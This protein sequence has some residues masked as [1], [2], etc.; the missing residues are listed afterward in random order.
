MQKTARAG[1]NSPRSRF[2]K[3]PK[4]GRLTLL[5]ACCLLLAAC[6]LLLATCYLL[7]AEH[8]S[9]NLHRCQPLR[10]NFTCDIIPASPARRKHICPDERLN[11]CAASAC[12]GS[13]STYPP[14]SGFTASDCSRP[15]KTSVALWLR[16]RF[17]H[18]ELSDSCPPQRFS[19]KNQRY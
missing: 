4:K 6:Y 18:A 19:E 3:M 1:L 10:H 7:L 13:S 9:R 17:H 14:P 8:H 5:A 12:C 2:P 11:P 16:S 15:A